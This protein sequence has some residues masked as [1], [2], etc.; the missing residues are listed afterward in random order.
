MWAVGRSRL[1]FAEPESQHYWS[2]VGLSRQRTEQKAGKIQGRA[3]AIV[4]EAWSLSQTAAVRGPN[5]N[6]Q[7]S[8]CYDTCNLL[9]DIL[10]KYNYQ[11]FL[12][13]RRL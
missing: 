2:S 10:K 13:A 3:W 9:L 1:A 11:F 8:G 4:V 5:S 12:V 6:T 7:K